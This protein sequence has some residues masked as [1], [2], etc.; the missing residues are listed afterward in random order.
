MRTSRLS[1]RCTTRKPR[2]IRLTAFCANNLLEITKD[3]LSFDNQNASNFVVIVGQKTLRKC[4][5]SLFDI[6]NESSWARAQKVCT[7]PIDPSR[8]FQ[9][10]TVNQSI[11]PSIKRQRAIKGTQ[12]AQNKHRGGDLLSYWIFP[13]PPFPLPQPTPSPFTALNKSTYFQ[14]FSKSH[15][16]LTPVTDRAA[17]FTIF[18]LFYF[19][20]N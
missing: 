5:S 15:P 20:T 10:K 7:Q 12:R 6:F 2:V 17:L 14:Y 13:F 9:T 8:N 18:L 1:N 19:K 4:S 16:I 3:L 11:G